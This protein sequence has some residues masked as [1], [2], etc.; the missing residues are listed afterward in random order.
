MPIQV[1]YSKRPLA[2]ICYLDTALVEISPTKTFL[3]KE[4]SALL[5]PLVSLALVKLGYK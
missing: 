2:E 5:T 1:L 3:T 4:F